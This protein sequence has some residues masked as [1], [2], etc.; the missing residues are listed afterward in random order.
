[1]KFKI[2]ILVVF[3]SLNCFAHKDILMQ[4]TYGNVK[5]IIK[6]GFDYSDIDKIQIIGQLSQKLSDR[7]HYKDTV[8]IEYLQDY[9]N[10]CKD[11]LYMLEYNNSNYKIIGGI[12]SEYNNESNNSGLSIRI[13]A[14][15]ITIVNT[16]KLVE[17]TIKNK[18]KTNKYLSKKKIGMNNDEDETLI[19]SLSTLATNDDL[20]AKIITSKSELIND[21]ISDKIPIKKQKHYGIE[22][23]WQN[24]KF[25]FEYKHINSDRQEYVFEVK[26]YFYHNYLN[27]NDI[28][29]FVDK[30]AFYFLEGTNHEKKELIKMDNKSYAPLIIFE[31]GNKILLHPFTNRN[32]LSLFLKEKNK[33]IS[34]FE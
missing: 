22:I 1:M 5:I 17:F 30:D 20:I 25:I 3:F 34:K 33:V 29:I 23:Y 9:T 15:R 21:I 27:E 10:I 11:D 24:D 16:L 19:D 8:F 13:Y 32:E 14:D 28:L 12:Q 4:R 7:L 31:F 26:D 2:G 6:T 18:A